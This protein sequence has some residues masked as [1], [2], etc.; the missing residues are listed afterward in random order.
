[1]N[2]QTS[3]PPPGDFKNRKTGLV[4]FGIMT[5]AMGGLCALLVPLMIFGLARAATTAGV[6]Q[7]LQSRSRSSRS[8]R[9]RWTAPRYRG[10]LGGAARCQT[11]FMLCLPRVVTSGSTSSFNRPGLLP[12]SIATRYV[13]RVTFSILP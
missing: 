12:M 6:H 13:S 1:M 10:G 8:S 3:T 2:Q 9:L 4:V 7:N 11:T 5:M